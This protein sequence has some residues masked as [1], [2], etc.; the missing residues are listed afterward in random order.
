MRPV[1]IGAS[2][3]VKRRGSASVSTAQAVRP[4]SEPESGEVSSGCGETGPG[5]LSAVEG[6]CRAAFGVL[7]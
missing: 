3:R 4:G 5:A 7:V 2:D 6:A 1:V